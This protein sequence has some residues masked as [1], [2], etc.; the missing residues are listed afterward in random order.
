MRVNPANIRIRSPNISS[1]NNLN[2]NFEESQSCKSFLRL[3]GTWSFWNLK[4]QKN[5][6][7]V[8]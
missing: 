4:E 6:G 3:Y 7:D 2:K 1:K 5:N 8:T